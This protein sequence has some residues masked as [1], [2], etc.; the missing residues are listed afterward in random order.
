MEDHGSRRSPAATAGRRR[1][2]PAADDA[3]T[4]AL[5][6]GLVLTEH[7]RTLTFAETARALISDKP[8]TRGGL[9]ALARAVGE[10]VSYGLLH[11]NGDQL[12]PS[13]AALRF[14]ELPFP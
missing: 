14:D 5:V 3:R 8:E 10:L 2:P 13:R 1:A 9:D 4:Q 12:V 6:L 7:P 11:H